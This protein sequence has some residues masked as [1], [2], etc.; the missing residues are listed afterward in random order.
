[1]EGLQLLFESQRVMQEEIIARLDA[2][3]TYLGDRDPKFWEEWPQYLAAAR[4]QAEIGS[5]L[6]TSPP[7]GEVH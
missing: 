4:K 6:S 5:S 3:Q 7:T 2:I 1:M